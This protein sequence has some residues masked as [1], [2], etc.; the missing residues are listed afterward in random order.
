Q[1]P[2]WSV[3]RTW[4]STDADDNLGESHRAA[5]ANRSKAAKRIPPRESEGGERWK[6][7]DVPLR[8]KAS[9][10]GEGTGYMQPMNF[11]WSRRTTCRESMPT[12]AR[13]HSWVA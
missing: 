5:K 3:E 11:P 9:V 12:K 1:R 2:G 8:S 10:I 7:R 6:C 4:P 13:I